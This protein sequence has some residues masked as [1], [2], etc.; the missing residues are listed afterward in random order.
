[1]ARWGE[2]GWKKLLRTARN[3]RI[4]HM[5]MEWMKKITCIQSIHNYMPR[6]NHIPRVYNAAHILW[7]KYM[8]YVTLFLTI[9][10]L[11]FYKINLQSICIV[12][13]PDKLFTY[14]LNHLEMVP[15][16]PVNT[17]F[18]FVFTF[19]I[20]LSSIVRFLYFTII[21]AHAFIIFLYHNKNNNNN[22]RPT[23]TPMEMTAHSHR[24][25]RM[26]LS[27]LLL[28]KKKTN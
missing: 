23:D 15:A 3:C 10:V 24:V 9:N 6:S 28:Y 13:F 4:L 2:G 26:N 27:K 12:P 7:L 17:G 18:T 25:W 8:A 5:P 21:L 11:Y 16:A 14:F 19:C 22:N 1:M 20:W